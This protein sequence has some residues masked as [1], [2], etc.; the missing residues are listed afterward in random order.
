MRLRRKEVDA[1]EIR[2]ELEEWRTSKCPSPELLATYV[3]TPFELTPSRQKAV[4]RHLAKCAL[5]RADRRDFR[6][7]LL[8]MRFASSTRRTENKDRTDHT[9]QS[10][11]D[12]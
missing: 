9:G 12:R 6:E 5:C 10:D 7:L 8:S 11:S 3:I 4:E 1:P 2:D